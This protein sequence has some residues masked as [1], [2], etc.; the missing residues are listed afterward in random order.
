MAP[1]AAPLPPQ[2]Q[3]LLLDPLVKEIVSGAPSQATSPV[4]AGAAMGSGG[5]PPSARGVAALGPMASEPAFREELVG[6]LLH[7]LLGH[8]RASGGPS[9]V[10]AASGAVVEAS[11]LQWLAASVDWMATARAALQGTKACLGWDRVTGIR[12]TGSTAVVDLWLQLLLR[13]FTVSGR[14]RS[15]LTAKGIGAGASAGGAGGAGGTASPQQG[16]PLLPELNNVHRRW[17]AARHVAAVSLAC[18]CGACVQG[19]VWVGCWCGHG[20]QAKQQHEPLLVWAWR[21]AKAAA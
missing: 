13:A 19:W 4:A 8:A 16:Q 10:L 12:S 5:R 7:V 14:I 3:L 21:T 18:S 20:G 17:V 15:Y 6:S 2:L 1:R 11:Q 9:G